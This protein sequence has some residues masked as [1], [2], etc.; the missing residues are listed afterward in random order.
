MRRDKQHG[1]K[2]GVSSSVDQQEVERLTLSLRSY[3]R[4]RFQGILECIARE[5]ARGQFWFWSF[6]SA[7]CVFAG[8]IGVWGSYG[9]WS[10]VI[11]CVVFVLLCYAIHWLCD[12]RALARRAVAWL[13]AIHEQHSVVVYHGIT[14]AYVVL[15]V[16][17]IEY[18]SYDDIPWRGISLSGTVVRQAIAELRKSGSENQP[19]E[20]GRDVSRNS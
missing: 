2:R 16:A 12:G 1:A 17:K 6:F 9:W 8:V 3:P 11:G 5:H 19:V 15:P 14:D 18:L 13:H 7:A 20:F 10:V 4:A